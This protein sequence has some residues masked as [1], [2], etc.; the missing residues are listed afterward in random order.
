MIQ[1]AEYIKD[2][3]LEVYFTDGKT[4]TIDLFSFLSTSSHPLINKYL[5]VVLFKQFRVEMG[6]ICWGDNEFDLN[7]MNIYNGQYDAKLEKEL[8][9]V[10][11]FRVNRSAV[12]GHKKSPGI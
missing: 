10:N 7:P 12:T 5:N 6:T 4:C 9:P 11:R 3:Q 8:S 1:K 2:Y